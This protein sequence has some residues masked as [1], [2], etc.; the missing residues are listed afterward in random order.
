MFVGYVYY[1][2]SNVERVHVRY[3]ITPLLFGNL[4]LLIS[5]RN[6]VQILT[7]KVVYVALSAWSGSNGDV[8]RLTNCELFLQ[9]AHRSKSENIEVREQK[10]CDSFSR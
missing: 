10:L 5:Y 1:S 2:I 8:I 6:E 9:H 7:R 4:L 3:T